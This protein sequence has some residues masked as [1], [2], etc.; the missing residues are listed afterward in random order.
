MSE[1]IRQ[2][3]DLDERQLASVRFGRN[4]F[5]RALGVA[6]FGLVIQMVAPQLARAWHGNP[7]YPCFVYGK[8][9]CCNSTQ[10]CSYYGCRYIQ[11]LGC[12]GGGQCWSTCITNI[13][14]RCCDWEEK[15][16]STS[17]WYPCICSKTVQVG[18]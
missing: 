4:R 9:H 15:T 13:L 12:P 10:C 17:P 8:C 1:E 14:Y 2:L 16:S 11:W 3:V 7:P 5:L 6:L 18:C